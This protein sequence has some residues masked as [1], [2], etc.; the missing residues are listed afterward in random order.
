MRKRLCAL[1]IALFAGACQPGGSADTPATA[2]KQSVDAAAAD[3]AG[4][5]SLLQ[6]LSG[7]AQHGDAVGYAS[8]FDSAGALM[9]PNQPAAVGRAAVEAWARRMLATYELRADSLIVAERRIGG[10]VAFMRYR[11]KGVYIPKAGGRPVPFDFKYIDT[12]VKTADG[13]WR[14]AA[15]IANSNNKDQSVFR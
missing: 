14:I 8:Q 6:R 12:Y 1:A 9:A 13:S 5:D 15:H 10:G 4:I 7:A 3:A 2:A 11:G